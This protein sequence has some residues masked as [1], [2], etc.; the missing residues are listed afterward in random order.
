[1]D[2]LTE[3]DFWAAATEANVTVADIKTVT[4]VESKGSGFDD[5]GLPF[6][7]FEGHIFSRLT[8]GVYDQAHPGIS[9]PNWTRQWY[10]KGPTPTARN[11]KEHVRLQEAAAL[12]REA[13]LKSASWGLF[14]ILGENH[15]SAG[16]GTVQSFVN[17]MY[18]GEGPQLNAFVNFIKN[19]KKKRLNGERAYLVDSLREHRW[20]DFAYGYNGPAYAQNQYDKKLAQAHATYEKTA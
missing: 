9:F 1:M 19:E 12:D 10:A 15:K 11:T 13:A 16:H 14:Q 2:K 8:N 17:A 3:A 6:I 18:A 5:N 7:L 20:A 4:E